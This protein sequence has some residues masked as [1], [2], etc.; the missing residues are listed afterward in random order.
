F[1][2]PPPPQSVLAVPNNGG[3]SQNNNNNN[4]ISNARLGEVILL[5]GRRV[6]I[7][8]QPR[9]FAGDLFDMVAS[10][11]NL[12]E[13]EYF[14]LAFL[15]ETGQ[16]SWL[17]L[18]KRVLEHEYAQNV[19][20]Q[21]SKAKHAQV[22]QKEEEDAISTVSAKSKSTSSSL[23]EGGSQLSSSNRPVHN[24]RIA[25]LKRKKQL[26]SNSQQQQQQ[27]LSSKAPLS[28]KGSLSNLSGSLRAKLQHGAN[29]MLSRLMS[30]TTSLPQTL[31]SSSHSSSSSIPL[32]D[33]LYDVINEEGG[34]G[35]NSRSDNF[36]CT[37]VT[38]SVFTADENP[39]DHHHHHHHHHHHLDLPYDKEELLRYFVESIS[40]LADTTTIELFFLQAKALLIN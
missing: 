38:N 29:G 30:S 16:Y 3:G 21:S 31:S 40:M 9:L 25:D 28:K 13:K 37:E 27:Q 5:D 34:S 36:F 1:P 22:I 15:D 2:P 8:I 32:D 4:N 11:F 10:H 24:R 39:N 14:G 35:G 17:N 19:F 26:S 33:P 6:E 18:E 20:S 12:K 7:K 23:K